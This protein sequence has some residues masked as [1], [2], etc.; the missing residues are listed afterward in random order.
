MTDRLFD[1]RGVIVP[2]AGMSLILAFAA[3]R[4]PL[5]A[6]AALGGVLLLLFVFVWAEAVLLV[7]L[8]ALPWESLLQYPT[9]TVSAVKL[10]GV[11][12]LGAWAFRVLQRGSELR[13]PGTLIPVVG[14]GLVI[15]VSLILSPDPSAG[16]DK[17]LRYALFITFFFL[18]LQLTT[19]RDS[20]KRILRVL[21]LS[22]TGAALWALVAFLGGELERAGGPISDPNDFAYLIA[23]VLPLTAYLW[24]EDRGRRVLWGSCFAVQ[25][26]AT[27][28]TLS[29]G[30]LV[31]LAALAVWAIATR[32]VP[33]VGV[34]AAVGSVV[35]V[36]LVALTFWSP[37]IN[38]RVES[39]EK[40]QSENAASRLAFWDAA[41]RMS[42]DRPVTG[43]GPAR[44]SEEAE[45]YVRGTTSGIQKPVAHNSYLEI[46]AE[47]GFFALV[48]F[49]AYIVASWGMLGRYRRTS[50]LM[51]DR[52]GARLAT[53]LQAAFVVAIVGAFFLSQQLALPL[54]LVGALAAA[55][56]QGVGATAPSGV[57]AGA[58]RF[59][60]S[61]PA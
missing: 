45:T 33:V 7:L 25:A 41:L 56:S 24:I 6:L 21:A 31:G 17:V 5:L 30:A 37:L 44:F 48:L 34:L 18:I 11:L 20:I 2:A 53:A 36:V 57:S 3:A 1:G 38:E 52:D 29:R 12:L 49:I 8:A 22:V 40:V 27:L 15:G 14:L 55:L 28:A 61:V 26:A 16:V 10:L 59:G 32:R 46:L 42:Y 19:G 13:L 43:V 51:A 39:K 23:A 50:V 4:S 35:A 47:N 9:E 58:P 60:A 54:W